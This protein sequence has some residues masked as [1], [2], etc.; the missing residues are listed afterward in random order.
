MTS[1]PIPESHTVVRHGA[2][3]VT[4]ALSVCV[5]FGELTDPVRKGL[6]DVWQRVR[7]LYESKL[8]WFMTEAMPEKQPV[9]DDALGMPAFWFRPG[10]RT[11]DRYVFYSYA[12][13]SDNDVGPYGVELWVLNAAPLPEQ[14][15]ALYSALAKTSADDAGKQANCLRLSFPPP[16]DESGIAEFADLCRFVFARVPFLSGYAGYALLFDEDSASFTSEAWEAILRIAMRHPGYDVFQY[17][18]GAPFL[19]FHAKGANW[20]TALGEPFLER[21]DRLER[22]A[23]LRDSR[24]GVTRTNTSVLIQAGPAPQIGD[25]NRGD[26]L[27]LYR[28]VAKAIEPLTCGAH[29]PFSRVFD[30]EKTMRWLKRFDLAG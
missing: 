13:E 27:P 26:E 4:P 12:G 10:A 15:R 14:Y 9:D 1:V 6:R 7:P 21:F 28:Q 23:Y 29:W 20:I 8:A 3:V 22:A 24:L 16:A 25:L 30:E 5:Y 2:R 18:A 11:R 17:D 19:Y